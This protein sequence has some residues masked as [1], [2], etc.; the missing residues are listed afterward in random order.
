[1]RGFFILLLT[2]P[3]LAQAQN[4]ELLHFGLKADLAAADHGATLPVYLRGQVDG[5]IAFVRE[6]GGQVK[7]TFKGVV[8]AHLPVSAFAKLGQA[9]AVQ[10]VEYHPWGGE[11]LSDVVLL[12]NNVTAVHDG[13]APLPESYRG[14]DVILGIIDT[15]IE[16]DHPD[17]QHEDGSTR[18][19]ALWDQVQAEIDPQRVP[20]PFGYGQEYTAEDLDAGISNHD[21]Q[22]QF[23]G[24][25]STV[26]GVAAGNA[27]ATGD[28]LGV[29]PEADL[30]VVSSNFSAPNWTMTVAEAVEWIFARADAIGKPAVINASLGSYLGSHDGLDAAALHIDS[31]LEAAPGRAMVCAAGNSNAWEPYHLSYDVP[32]ADTAFTWFAFN[33]NALENGA[34]FFEVWADAAQFDN[35]SFTIGAD[36]VSPTYAFR[37]YAGWR[38]AAQNLNQV[39][40]DT[41]FFDGAIIGRVQSWMGQR[42]DQY[43]LQVAVTEPFSS[44]FRWRFA[45]T[46]GGR[47]SCWSRAAFGMSDMVSSNLPSTAAYPAMASYRMP[48]KLTTMVDSWACSDKVL[49]VANYVNQTSFE[50]YSG[51]TTTYDNV[52]AGDLSP[53]SSS[54]PTRDLRQKPD[55]ASTGDVTLSA[56]RL[57][58]LT[59]L[60]S[61]NP[62]N[63]A[64]SGMHYVNGGTSMA[65]PVVAAAAALLFERCPNATYAEVHDLIT[66]HTMADEFTGELPGLRF[67]HGKLDVF[68]TLLATVSPVGITA[69]TPLC[70]GEPTML[71]ADPGFFD[72]EWNTGETDMGITVSDAGPYSVQARDALGCLQ[73]SGPFLV[74]F[75]DAP[76]VPVIIADG[77]VLEAMGTADAWQWYLDEVAIAGATNASFEPMIDGFY[78]VEAIGE[79]GCGT[80]SEPF[81]YGVVGTEDQDGGEVLLFPN[82]ASDWVRLRVPGGFD[83]VRIFDVQGRLLKSI[84]TVGAPGVA[85][86]ISTSGIPA[87]L[88]ILT[89]ESEGQ[90][91]KLKVALGK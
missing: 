91:H 77:D 87:G 37:G 1:M 44:Q 80:F 53:N 36:V 16:L 61:N 65:S 67:G 75:L 73:E 6:E 43:V 3:F 85:T 4:R 8:S 15:G 58:T 79:N 11:A 90:T 38:N 33:P 89:Y 21:D 50:N 18:V 64:F 69:P 78:A 17:F 86:E 83:T 23:F 25:G 63:V 22:S 84:R 2:L 52:T 68:S 56:G 45:T 71:S 32:D 55:V 82:P 10:F 20:Q 28:F 48:D 35:T 51:G 29:A 74:D 49:T 42:G 13:L 46:G 70:P 41:I 5:I 39:M 66:G 81:A 27:N 76:A 40:T 12:N 88:Y 57:G 72:Y 47:F 60:I 9:D 7:G 62:G 59:S 34:V 30:V 54:G 31:L 24:H 14:K 19:I 26:T